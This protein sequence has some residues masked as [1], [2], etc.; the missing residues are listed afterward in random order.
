MKLTKKDAEGQWFI[1]LGGQLA[2][3]DRYQH[4]ATGGYHWGDT[5]AGRWFNERGQWTVTGHEHEKNLVE[6]I[7]GQTAELLL[8]LK[9]RRR[10][11]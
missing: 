10:L 5:S 6:R 3:I 1:T 2:H 11:S 4:D 7:D 8:S 9:I